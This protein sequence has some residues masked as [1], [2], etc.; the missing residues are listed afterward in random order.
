MKYYAYIFIKN[1][2]LRTALNPNI[3]AL[4]NY[5][6]EYPK[7][8]IFVLETDSED[9]DEWI[10]EKPIQDMYTLIKIIYRHYFFLNRYYTDLLTEEVLYRALTEVRKEY[11]ERATQLN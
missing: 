5:K 7:G 8:E 2:V 1:N 4:A 10:L 6:K 3:G 9:S 11:D